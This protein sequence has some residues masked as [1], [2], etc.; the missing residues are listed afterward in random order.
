MNNVAKTALGVGTIKAFN[1]VERFKEKNLNLIDTDAS[2][3]FH[4]NVAM[5][6]LILILELLGNIVLFTSALVLISLPLS[7]ITPR[8]VG[9]SLSYTLSLTS[10]QV[11]M[12]Q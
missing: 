8:F 9:L 3:L 6:W 1:M 4:S 7:S 2:P 5:E 12:V 11:F 10:C